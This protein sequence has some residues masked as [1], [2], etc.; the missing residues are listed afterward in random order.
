MI[1]IDDKFLVVSIPVIRCFEPNA[2]KLAGVIKTL[3]YLMELIPHFPRIRIVIVPLCD[4]E[5]LLISWRNVMLVQ[6]INSY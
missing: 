4:F 2:S 6:D 3:G 5:A 1:G